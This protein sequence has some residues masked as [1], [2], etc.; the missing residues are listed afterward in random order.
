MQQ[1]NYINSKTKIAIIGGTSFI[2]AKLIFLI[3]KNKFKII[4]TYNNKKNIVKN[5]KITW[6]KLNLNKKKKIILNI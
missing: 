5:K 1:K 2:G 4:A 6:K 3:P